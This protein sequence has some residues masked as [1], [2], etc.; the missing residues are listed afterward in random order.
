MQCNTFGQDVPICWNSTYLMLQKVIAYKAMFIAWLNT[1]L[2][3]HFL[4][5]TNW[6]IAEAMQSFLKIFC[7][8]TVSLSIIY[9]PTTHLALQEILD[10]SMCFHKHKESELLGTV[11]PDME[12]KF[13]RYWTDIQFLYSFALILEPL[14]KLKNFYDLLRLI[15]D[16]IGMTYIETIYHES[17]S[18][19]Y[20]VYISYE[21]E[22]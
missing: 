19:F 8:I 20:V 3:G 21:E 18:R 13:K 9:T 15:G 4:T 6:T 22:Y 10:Y 12:E 1:E 17:E 5:D 11:V 14:M 7:F 16:N 2:G